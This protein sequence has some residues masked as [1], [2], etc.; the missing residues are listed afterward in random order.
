[1]VSKGG[2]PEVVVAVGTTGRLRRCLL[3]LLMV[4]A[5]VPWAPGSAAAADGDPPF[6][7]WS[8][9]LPATV[10]QYDPTSSDDCVAGRESC[11]RKAIRTMQ[12]QLDGL[13][14]TCDHDA[15]FALAYLR[16]TEAYLRS[17]MTEGFYLDPAFV[18]HEDIVFAELYFDAYEAWTA[19]R[20]ERV[21][22]AWRVA[23]RAADR[24]QVSGQGN[25]LLGMNAHINRDLPFVLAAIG[26]ATPSGQSRKRDH[27][28][29][30]V[31]LNGVADALIAEEAARFDPTMANAEVPYDLNYTGLMQMLMAWRETA[32]R[33][34]ERLVAAPDAAA[35]A[36]VAEEIETYAY[37]KAQAL[38]T[39]TGYLA[40]LSSS[41]ARDSYCASRRAG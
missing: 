10:Y 21:P 40:P 19:G 11:V 30:N 26:L 29:V 41:A 23:L 36:V 27:D 4:A 6:I 38:A 33:N 16:T 31:M 24:R 9:V 5:L 2:E 8:A 28:Q 12:H 20:I 3:T 7:G 39:A 15:V 22:P 25:L 17:S 18:N 13:A 37:T 14:A 32:W 35:R 34:A 1:M